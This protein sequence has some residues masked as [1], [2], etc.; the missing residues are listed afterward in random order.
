VRSLALLALFLSSRAVAQGSPYVPLDHPLLPLAEYLIARGDIDDPTPMI[1]PF[2]RADLVQAIAK[3]NLPAATRSGRIAAELTQAFSDRDDDAWFRVAP[4]AGVQAFSRARRDLLHPA[5]PSQATFYA[6]LTLEG[7]FGPIVAVTRPA[8]ENRLKRDPDWAGGAIQQRKTQAYRFVDGY[9][10]AQWSKARLFY[11]QMSRNWGPVGAL[12][13]SLS[14][15]GYPRS[16]LGFD[17]VLRDLQLDVVAT[18]LPDMVSRTGAVHKRYFLAHRLNV[19]ATHRLHLAIWETA[20]LAGENRS[21]DPTFRNPMIVAAFPLQ[22][23]LADDRNAII[24]GDLRWRV[25]R[26]RLEGQAMIDDRWR[27]KPDP[28]GTGEPAHPG[29]WAATLVGAGPLGSGAA[30]RIGLA[31]VNSLAYRTGDSAQSFLDRGVGIGPNFTD[32]YQVTASVSVPVHRRWL[33]SPDLTLLRQ[34]EGRID[35][36]FPS[37]QAL[38]DTPELF[39]GT[40]ATTYRAGARVAGSAGPFDLVADLGLHRLTNA[41]HVPGASRTRFEARV[42]ATLGFSTGGMLR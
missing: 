36:P 29:R 8:A 30:W 21:F 24:G 11:G 6:D 15:Y 42:Q 28:N 41:D 40:V 10:A 32:N 5:G 2:R 7:R 19:R 20:I 1:R 9:L 35:A 38:T 17:L 16:D 14:D 25:G 31:M 23:G 33:V 18:Q 34:G 39:I 13:L 3:A 27:S 22:L 26:V 12:G 4:R 37:G